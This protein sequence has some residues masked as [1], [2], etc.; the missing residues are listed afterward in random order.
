MAVSGTMPEIRRATDSD[1]KAI[2]KLI[3]SKFVRKQQ[4]ID[5]GFLPFKLGSSAITAYLRDSTTCVAY[6][7]DKLAGVVIALNKQTLF[8]W[9]PEF[10]ES[11]T[12]IPETLEVP[13]LI[14]TTWHPA[15]VPFEERDITHIEMVATAK[16]APAGAFARLYDLL[17]SI[18]DTAFITGE[19]VLATEDGVRN[20][21]SFE[22][23]IKK[24][25]SRFQYYRYDAKTRSHSLTGFMERS[26]L[27]LT[28]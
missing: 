1:A 2:K 15:P 22:I 12:E 17:A 23:H 25:D 27:L 21:R 3:N 4:R 9:Y 18:V 14:G 6:D 7:G 8:K 11:S 16:N 13:E 19:I 28:A 26:K 10:R 5:R 20:D 24:Y